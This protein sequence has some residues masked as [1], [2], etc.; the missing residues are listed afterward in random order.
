MVSSSAGMPLTPR[1]RARLELLAG[2]IFG[3]LT[4]GGRVTSE[5]QRSLG[6]ERD[7]AWSEGCRKAFGAALAKRRKELALSQTALGRALGGVGQ[8]AISQWERG[9]IQPRPEYVYAVEKA[10]GL[11]P[12]TLS[13]TL[14][15]LPPTRPPKSGPGGVREAIRR[16]PLLTSKEKRSLVS[17]YDSLT[18]GRSAIST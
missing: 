3:S 10:L 4:S 12:G 14:G 11:A 17:L 7:G 5:Q 2:S 8:S 6:R 15:Y 16:D 1:A 9:D 13:R 18:A